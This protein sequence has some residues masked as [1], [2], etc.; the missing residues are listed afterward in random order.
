MAKIKVQIHIKR[1]AKRTDS[2]FY[3]GHIA[4]IIKDGKKV[5]VETMGSI[6]GYFSE[7]GKAYGDEEFQRQLVKRGYTDKKL[8]TLGSNDMVQMGNWFRIVRE[9]GEGF[10]EIQGDYDSALNVAKQIAKEL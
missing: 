9:D 6:K 8:K 2:L 3:R 7:K 4:T 5:F 10:E 1:K